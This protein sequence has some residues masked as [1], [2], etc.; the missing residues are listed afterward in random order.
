MEQATVHT[1]RL[2]SRFAWCAT[3]TYCSASSVNS[4]LE[5]SP[6]LARLSGVRRQQPRRLHQDRGTVTKL[7]TY[8][9]DVGNPSGI[10]Q[11]EF[12]YVAKHR[13][14]RLG[15]QVINVFNTET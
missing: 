6:N 5:I 9:S 7:G 4:Q 1:T 3:V 15:P 2:A 14:T 12:A 11:P 13:G 10:G 8:R